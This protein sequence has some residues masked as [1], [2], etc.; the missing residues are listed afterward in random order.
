[1]AAVV[2]KEGEDGGK[3]WATGAVD[4]VVSQRSVL[5]EKQSRC[6]GLGCLLA[7]ARDGLPIRGKLG[8]L[9]QER[10]SLLCGKPR[11]DAFVFR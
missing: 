1:M 8:T 2:G 9:L 11:F 7:A 3:P 6:V 4:A 10:A 5:A